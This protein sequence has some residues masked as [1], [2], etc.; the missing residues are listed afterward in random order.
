MARAAAVYDSA[1]AVFPDEEILSADDF[2]SKLD[3]FALMGGLTIVEELDTV[4]VTH[5]SG[6]SLKL[7]TLFG[8]TVR[9]ALSVRIGG[10]APMQ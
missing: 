7:V 10:Y 5:Q 4:Q 1:A 3:A 2:C 9:G 8:L 6:Q